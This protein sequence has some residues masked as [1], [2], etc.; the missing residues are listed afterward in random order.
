MLIA[1]HCFQFFGFL[2]VAERIGIS[3][4]DG[5]S[6]YLQKRNTPNGVLFQIAW[7]YTKHQ[8]WH[9]CRSFLMFRWSGKKGKFD[10]RCGNPFR[11]DKWVSVE[12]YIQYR[13]ELKYNSVLISVLVIFFINALIQGTCLVNF[14][15]KCDFCKGLYRFETL[16]L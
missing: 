5:T 7:W 6:Q 2:I 11:S 1:L 10:V 16:Y 4:S 3:I 15:S 14:G 12:R 8:R 9:Q 13:M